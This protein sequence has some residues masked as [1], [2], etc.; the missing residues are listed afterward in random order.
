MEMKDSCSRLLRRQ[1]RHSKP[2]K[3]TLWISLGSSLN[4]WGDVTFNI[5]SMAQL[6]EAMLLTANASGVLSSQWGHLCLFSIKSGSLISPL[7]SLSSSRIHFML[8]ASIN[9]SYFWNDPV[10]L[11]NN[12]EALILYLLIYIRRHVTTC[13]ANHANSVY[14]WLVHTLSTHENK[15]NNMER[16]ASGMV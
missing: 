11:M 7:S 8:Y 12:K 9:Y 13:H 14:F 5:Y 16:V 6:C 15:L 10:S 1:V 3:C 4:F 2:S